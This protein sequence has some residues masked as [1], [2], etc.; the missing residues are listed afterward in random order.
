MAQ[1]HGKN[2]ITTVSVK[3]CANDLYNHHLFTLGISGRTGDWQIREDEVILNRGGSYRPV[4]SKRTNL[5][6]V[7]VIDT[8]S[9]TAG[10]VESG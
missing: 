8:A 2:D 3:S 7:L 5:P 4:K 9:L 10:Q 6:C 1:L